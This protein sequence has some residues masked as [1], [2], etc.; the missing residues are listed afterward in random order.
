MIFRNRKLFDQDKDQRLRRK[1]STDTSTAE[2]DYEDFCANKVRMQSYDV[3]SGTLLLALNATERMTSD[4]FAIAKTSG[5]TT[6]LAV[7][8]YNVK[9][10]R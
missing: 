3:V 5:D 4:N 9:N 10:V 7:I 8:Q 1:R 2:P 6:T